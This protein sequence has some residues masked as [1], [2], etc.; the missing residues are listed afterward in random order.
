MFLL[1]LKKTLFDY[2]DNL[3]AF[4]LMNIFC[5]I[6]A[7]LITAALY[8]ST[9]FLLFS[10]PVFIL[11]V[12][13]LFFHLNGISK[14]ALAVSD[15]KYPSWNYFFTKKIIAPALFM[16]LVFLLFCFLLVCYIIFL[17]RS[18]SQLTFI[19]AGLYFWFT[20][21]FL[22]SIVF[23]L[24]L[25]ERIEGATLFS[26]IKTCFQ[27][28]FDN[29]IFAL[30]MF[31]G[32]CI[33]TILSCVTVLIFPGISGLIVWLHVGVKLRLKKYTYLEE[34]PKADRKNIPWT[35]L[36]K[37][38]REEVRNRSAKGFLFPWRP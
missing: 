8:Y 35:Q 19:L 21:T 28:F 38:E 9:S 17:S 22:L 30:Y 24:P 25:Y 4:S 33:F 12:I 5:Y 18:K 23:F 34:N 15:K 36:L 1:L 37:K 16:S 20:L 13:L 27:F 2:W 31:T 7:I 6:P 3:L 10:I 11:G 32:L 29:K 14:Y 26:T